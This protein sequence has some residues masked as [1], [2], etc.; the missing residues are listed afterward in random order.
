MEKALQGKNMLKPPAL[1]FNLVNNLMTR[2]YA[3]K[4]TR[5]SIGQ[6]YD[7]VHRR[8]LSLLDDV[9][10]DED[11]DRKVTTPLGTFTVAQLFQLHCNHVQEHAEEIRHNLDSDATRRV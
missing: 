10:K 11:L 4:Y 5:Q 3:K 9:I 8:A 2:R 7:A 6:S 1:I